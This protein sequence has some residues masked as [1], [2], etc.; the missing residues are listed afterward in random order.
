VMGNKGMPT[1]LA[2]LAVTSLTMLLDIA[3]AYA[4][5]LPPEVVRL[6][7]LQ[8]EDNVKT[9]YVG[10]ANK[11]YVLFCNVKTDGCI[12]PEE[13]KDYLLFN[14]DSRWMMPGATNF[15]TL[16]LMQEL[17]VTYNQGENIGLIA[18]DGS[19][20]IGMFV[21]DKTAGGYE[22]DTIISDG[23]II[24]GTYLSNEDR[25]KAWKHFFLMMVQACMQQQGQDACGVKLAPRCPPDQKFCMTT[26]DA[27]LVGIAGIQ[28]PRKVVVHVATDKKD[29][30]LQVLRMV[31]T[32]PTKER[33][34]CRDWSTGKLIPNEGQ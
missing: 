13:N 11:H 28:E 15:L 20:D 6:E 7:N 2:C 34:V 24:Y 21:F 1:K 29:R 32:W 22:K 18:K 16:A 33:K 17:T 10:N 25:Q 23:P 14:K 30:N 9:V 27:N 26:L 8:I 31:C 19:S 3:A 5:T 12:T 4:Q